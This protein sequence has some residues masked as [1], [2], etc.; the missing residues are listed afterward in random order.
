MELLKFIF[1]EGCIPEKC[2]VIFFSGAL[3]ALSSETARANPSVLKAV[4]SLEKLY[5][6]VENT[7][8]APGYRAGFSL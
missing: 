5:R 4:V 3:F 1:Y 6:R 7:S 8:P 2:A